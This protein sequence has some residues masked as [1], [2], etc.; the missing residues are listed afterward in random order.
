MGGKESIDVITN[1]L[2]F[3]LCFCIHLWIVTDEPGI[4]KK[5]KTGVGRVVQKPT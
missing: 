2:C 5:S 1:L 3:T 4:G